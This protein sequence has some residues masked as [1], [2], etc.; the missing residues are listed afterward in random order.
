[1]EWVLDIKKLL[2]EFLNEKLKS[3]KDLE[4]EKNYYL[5]KLIHSIYNSVFSKKKL[6][7]VINKNS[8]LGK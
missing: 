7:R 1:M 5:L 8:L 6:N 4:I 3:S 2:D